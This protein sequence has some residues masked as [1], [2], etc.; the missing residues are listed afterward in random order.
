FV[1]FRR[2]YCSAL[3]ARL[4]SST[5]HKIQL[6]QNSTARIL[7]CTKFRTLITPVL[8]WVEITKLVSQHQVVNLGQGFPDFSPP[9]FVKEAFIRALNSENSLMNQ[10]TRGF[11]HPPLVNILALFFGKLLGRDINALDEVLVTV[12]AYEALFCFFQAMV[13]DGDEV[14]IIE[15][16]FDCYEM[17]A[18]MAG[19]RPVFIP[20]QPKPVSGRMVTSADWE[21][22]PAELANKF[23]KRTKAVIL[24]NPN[25][26]LGKVFT[27]KELELIA[28]LC[29]KHD[30]LC[31]SD[32]VYEWLVYDGKEHVRIAT[33]PGMW[34]RT[35]TVGSG[36]KTFSATGWKV[37]WAIGPK[38]VLRHLRTVHQNTVF[39]CATAAQQ[40]VAEGLTKEL[41]CLG[42]PESYFISLPQELQRKRDRLAAS[43]NAAGLKSILPEGGYFLIADVTATSE[44]PWFDLPDSTDP[45]EL[46][47]DKLV[48][49]MITEQGLAAIPV[50]VFY[51]AEHKKEFE[52]YIRF[53]FAKE[54]STLS[55]AEKILQEWKK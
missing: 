17:M 1:S 54:D 43:I 52:N 22:D 33:L 30:V 23:T 13:D 25:N 24:N 15:P 27:R 4:P 46:Y 26:P 16:F 38:Q 42:K 18:Q 37:G 39:H 47:D 11:G 49:R 7:N 14:I 12:G 34:E 35:V 5:I 41:E 19:G 21:L 31:L 44:L 8:A 6:I 29:V 20:L 48:K 50:S 45:E 28:D 40:A 3:L 55:K 2:V 32:E 9:Q 53:C 10:Y 36:G 51:S